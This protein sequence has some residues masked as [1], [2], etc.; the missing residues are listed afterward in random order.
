MDDGMVKKLVYLM[1]NN[2]NRRPLS[3]KLNNYWFKPVSL[4]LMALDGKTE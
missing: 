1:R 3:F 4:K 2:N